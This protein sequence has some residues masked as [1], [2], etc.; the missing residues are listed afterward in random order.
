MVTWAEFS[1]DG[2]YRPH[3]LAEDIRDKIKRGDW[4]RAGGGVVCAVCSK[5]YTEHRT[6]VNTGGLKQ[7]CNGDLV[8]L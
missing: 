5:T 8:H 2:V 4:R 7:L 6:V 3:L 1:D